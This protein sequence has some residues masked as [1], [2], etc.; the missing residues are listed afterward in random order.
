M[1]TRYLE[2]IIEIGN[3][4]SITKAAENLYVSQSSLS[5][6]LSKLEKELGTPL[7]LRA[8]NECLP[9]AAGELYLAYAQKV[10]DIRK[11]TYDKIKITAK[12]E[13]ISLGSTSAKTLQLLYGLLPAFK[14]RFPHVELE[15]IDSNLSNIEKAVLNG[16]LDM[17]LVNT[18]SLFRFQGHSQMLGQEE[19]VFVLPPG[20][21]FVGSH[22]DCL[23]LTSAKIA[24]AFKKED[25]ILQK[26]GNCIRYLIDDFFR[27]QHF[28]PHTSFSINKADM[29]CQ[30]VSGGMGAAFLPLKHAAGAQVAHYSLS[31][32]MYRMTALICKKE[33]QE[34]EAVGYMKKLILSSQAAG[35]QN[36]TLTI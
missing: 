7:F 27:S 36:Y 5:Q 33:L 28:H 30:L 29:I 26:K 34:T 35:L 31:P 16:S 10:V 17:A 15:I 6:Y 18:Y 9:T 8:Q 2:Y 11:T 23:P 22:D 19:V 3:C 24:S 1:D 4:R 25:F 12:R 13:T 32:A 20:H 21:P 14:Q